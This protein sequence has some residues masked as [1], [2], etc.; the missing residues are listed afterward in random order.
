MSASIRTT[1][2]ATIALA[3][4]F[5]VPF[6]I[7][8]STFHYPDILREP[9]VIVLQRFHDGGPGL[10]LTWY[11]F[12]LSAV[13]MVP[14]AA[15]LA[16]HLPALAERQGARMIALTA[17]AAAGLL[18]AIGLSR[19]VFAVPAL[20]RLQTDP[21]A[22]DAAR[23]QAQSAFELLNNWGGVA[24]G[25]H[26]GQIFTVLFIAS[27]AVAQFVRTSRLDK[28]AGVAGILAAVLIAIG[29]GEG[30]ALATDTDAGML[31][32][33]TVVGYMAFTLWLILT[34]ASLL[35]GEARTTSPKPAI[36]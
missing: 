19:W 33:F 28:S 8:G 35:R 5:N 21:A 18:Q 31:G 2:L 6:A 36:A 4:G 24:I 30:V 1:G 3:L 23:L 14:V 27:L 10:V 12:M 32:L 11:A 20:A 17:G 25:E 22:T 26:L 29:L 16:M 15:A 34:G 13:L 9:A 7:L